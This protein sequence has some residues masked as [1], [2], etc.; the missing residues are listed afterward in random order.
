[1]FL[2]LMEVTKGCNFT[3]ATKYISFAK[4]IEEEV[5]EKAEAEAEE[6]QIEFQAGL[7]TS[8]SNADNSDQSSKFSTNRK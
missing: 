2:Q 1:M 6:K 3:R 5:D 4:D 8:E 7:N